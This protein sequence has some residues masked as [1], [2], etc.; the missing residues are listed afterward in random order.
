MYVGK[1]YPGCFSEKPLLLKSANLNLAMNI[2]V[3]FGSVRL[4]KI[5]AWQ[6]KINYLS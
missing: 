4:K 6:G 5:K 2:L 3:L 1:T